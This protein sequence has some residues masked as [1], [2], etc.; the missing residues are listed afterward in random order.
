MR[1]LRKVFGLLI[2]NAMAATPQGGRIL[3]ECTRQAHAMRVVVSDNGKG[4][5]A[6]ALARAMEGLSLG[7]GLSTDGRPVERRLGLGLPLVRQLIA[8]HGGQFELLSEPG[9]G[10]SAIVTLP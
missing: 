8:A 1:R 5:D 7:G 4:M 10:T 2:D 3:V 9:A 6:A